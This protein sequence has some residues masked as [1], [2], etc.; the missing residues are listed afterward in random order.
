MLR[1]T[2][3]AQDHLRCIGPNTMNVGRNIAFAFNDT[4]EP[5]ASELLQDPRT[6]HAIARLEQSFAPDVMLFDL[7]PALFYDDVIAFRPMFDG[8]L[9][10]IGGGQTTQREVKEVERRLG[11]NTPLLGMV[12]N[13]AE[14]PDFTR[15]GY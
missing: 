8:V 2:T 5:Y 14:G 15:Y 9:L 7:P 3:S 10:V 11:E 12:L 4:V 6:E 1:G 13:R